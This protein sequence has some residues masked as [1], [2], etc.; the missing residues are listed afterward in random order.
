[1]IQID[2]EMPS[3][4]YDCD[5]SIGVM[6][7]KAD[8]ECTITDRYVN[9]DDKPEWCPLIDVPEMNV[10]N[11]SEIPNSSTDC[12]S[13]QAA[14]DAITERADRCAEN[15]STDDPFWEGLVIAKSIVKGLPPVQAATPVRPERKESDWIPCSDR[16]PEK[17]GRYLITVDE[18]DRKDV[19]DD[20][21]YFREDGVPS[22]YVEKNVIAWMPL[23]EPYR[24][25]QE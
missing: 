21:F 7:T 13:R 19:S 14:V 18:G 4:C 17:E 16:P 12:I 24:G 8:R 25:E 9:D 22:W 23:P 1:M 15:F 3:C 2:M 6:S 10:G 5:F 20:F 11:I